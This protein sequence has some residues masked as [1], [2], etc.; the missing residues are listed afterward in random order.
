MK[1]KA[2]YK[3]DFTESFL[4]IFELNDEKKHDP[5]R[6]VEVYKEIAKAFT[7]KGLVVVFRDFEGEYTQILTDIKG[8]FVGYE[9]PI[10]EKVMSE[11]ALD[12]ME[13]RFEEYKD[14]KAYRRPIK[15]YL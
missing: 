3:F 15:G 6:K 12:V 8:D 11:L 1:R 13:M 7:V 10:K 14:E 2:D 9:I 4:V 5:D